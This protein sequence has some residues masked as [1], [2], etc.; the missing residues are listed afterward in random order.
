MNQVLKH[1]IYGRGNKHQIEFVA[2]LGGMDEEEKKILSMWHYQKADGYIQDILGFDK[3]T[4]GNVESAVRAKT[5]VAVFDCINTKMIL[6][7]NSIYLPAEQLIK[8]LKSQYIN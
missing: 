2:E 4:Y 3:K 6:T 1:E 5:L 7:N 8:Q